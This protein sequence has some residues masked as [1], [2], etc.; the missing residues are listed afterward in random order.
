LDFSISDCDN[1]SYTTIYGWYRDGEESLNPSIFGAGILHDANATFVIDN[2]NRST[3]NPHAMISPF[4]GLTTKYEVFGLNGRRLGLS[5]P[6]AGRICIM[7]S[8]NT[9][10]IAESK[11]FIK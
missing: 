4:E 8:R 5:Q 7:R 3:Q 2:R 10:S 6:G 11:I 1:E 9:N